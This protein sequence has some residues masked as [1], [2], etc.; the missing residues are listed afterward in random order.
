ML[1][2]ERRLQAI[3]ILRAEHDTVVGG[4][5]DEIDVDTR[6]GND[7]GEVGQGAGAI[8]DVDDHHL[9]LAGDNGFMG[10]GERMA[11]GLGVWHQD[12]EFGPITHPHARRRGEVDPG[13]ADRCRDLSK[14]A[15][16]VV[17][18][19]AAEAESQLVGLDG[20]VIE[21]YSQVAVVELGSQVEI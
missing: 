15:R 5:V 12:V 3:E 20:R 16:L 14:R 17:V 6:L 21:G 10:D 13:I 11:R 1:L 8:L 7:S 9:T 19:N 18:A 2:T 4:H